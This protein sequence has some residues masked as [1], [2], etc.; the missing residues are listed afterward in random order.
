MQSD[1]VYLGNICQKWQN[2]LSKFPHEAYERGQKLHERLLDEGVVYF[3]HQEKFLDL[4]NRAFYR[5]RPNDYKVPYQIIRD[6]GQTFI[7]QPPQIS[8]CP[9]F[10][11]QNRIDDL[12]HLVRDWANIPGLLLKLY[13]R[14]PMAFEIMGSEN[15]MESDLKVPVPYSSLTPWARLDT[16]RAY[17]FVDR[18]EMPGGMFITTYLSN[19]FYDIFG[20]WLADCGVGHQIVNFNTFSLWET[21]MRLYGEYCTYTKRTPNPQPT[22]AFIVN[23]GSGLRS[24]F[25][26]AKKEAIPYFGSDHVF[27]T[28]PS[29]LRYYPD[30]QVLYAGNRQIDIAF[31]FVRTPTWPWYNEA[32]RLGIRALVEASRDMAVC[33]IPPWKRYLSSH[34]YPFLIQAEQWTKALQADLGEDGLNRIRS[35]LPYTGVI[36]REGCIKWPNGNREHIANLSQT[37]LKRYVL[38]FRDSTGSRGVFILRMFR[39]YQR[40]RLVNEILGRLG[41][42]DWLVIQ[43]FIKPLHYPAF[44]MHSKRLLKMRL[45]LKENFFSTDDVLIPGGSGMLA[46]NNLKIHGGSGTWLT[47]LFFL[48]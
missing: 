42:H 28:D 19:I 41:D 35:S 33:S 6:D 18:N 40:D 27:V 22:L 45:L 23:R 36:N 17:Y 24:E 25:V 9:V 46:W 21:V 48:S 8:L 37:A 14:D 30:K 1:K 7:A 16:I 11:S 5:A 31:R 4:E 2:L 12:T 10:V 34:A 13:N 3:Y 47:P 39:S 44:V 29:T 38:K 20:D 15:S 26:L 43:E 32:E